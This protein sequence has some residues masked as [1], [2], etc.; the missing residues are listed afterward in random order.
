[1]EEALIMEKLWQLYRRYR[2]TRLWIRLSWSIF[3]GMSA[4][5]L[6]I[7]TSRI[8]GLF[9]AGLSFIIVPMIL[10]VSAGLVY[11][12]LKK[13]PLMEVALESDRILTLK[14][15]LSTALEWVQDQKVRTPMFRGLLRDTAESAGN[16]SPAE[17]F[18]VNWRQPSRRLTG[19]LLAMVV[20]FHVP[21]LSL[22]V[23]GV[24]P[25]EKEQIRQGALLVRKGEEKLKNRK[26]DTQEVEKKIEKA[27]KEMDRLA[28]E[29][30]KPGVDKRQALMK[31][32][33][34]QEQI[35]NLAPDSGA[36]EQMEEAMRRS[37]DESQ[38]KNETRRE[39]ELLD[40][41]SQTLKQIKR[42]AQKKGLSE[43]E[44]QDIRKKLDDTRQKME[45]AGMNTQ[46]IEK[47]IESARQ[48]DMDSAAREIQQMGSQ[49]QARQD[50][51]QGEEQLGDALS[52]AM[53]DLE[54]S[55]E[56][57]SGRRASRPF[58]G[59]RADYSQEG[60]EPADFGKGTTNEAAPEP[61]GEPGNIYG[62]RSSEDQSTTQEAFKK[63][64][65]PQRDEFE[66]FTGKVSGK[67]SEGPVIRSIR[68]SVR[69]AP[70]TGEEATRDPAE[71]Y[72]D[73]RAKGEE[74]VRREQIPSRYRSLIRHYYDDINPGK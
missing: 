53:K 22:L 15:R 43:K 36:M 32:S 57:V 13:P 49:F 52:Q 20:F 8:T 71:V 23:P 73:A 11:H 10:A 46:T 60:S 39:R 42:Q 63:L 33:K 35:K 31:I 38:Q 74:A 27:R 21:Q 17:V 58:T 19:A 7:L 61:T 30:E 50:Q 12:K 28:R 55:K 45:Q 40:Q 72:V 70:T 68:S 64:Y 44:K 67:L 24:S 5:A 41:L 3:F 18:P 51:L 26:V 1:M 25:Q 62:Q 29:L 69:G 6:L 34:A 66:T 16:I 48:G 56:M 4:S 59:Q 65:E 2:L 47:A 14:E 9:E 54:E 37:G